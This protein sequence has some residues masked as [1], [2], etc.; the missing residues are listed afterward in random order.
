MKVISQKG[1]GKYVERLVKSSEKFLVVV[2]PWISERYAKMVVK[3][4]TDGVNVIVVTTRDSEKIFLKLLKKICP[5]KNNSNKMLIF[6]SILLTPFII[7]IILLLALFLKSRKVKKK[8]GK[9]KVIV[10]DKDFFVHVKAYINEKYA[11]VGSVNLTERG[12]WKNVEMI[13]MF[14]KSKDKDDYESIREEIQKV[15]SESEANAKKVLRC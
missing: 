12:L 10:V 1:V 11:I 8:E 6:I 3:K 13:T 15:I 9:I 2:S 5:Q 7:G 4:S 14:I